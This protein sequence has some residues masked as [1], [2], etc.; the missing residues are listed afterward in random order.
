MVG[1]SGDDFGDGTDDGESFPK[2]YWR[3]NVMGKG[4]GDHA[5]ATETKPVLLMNL[6]P[7]VFRSIL[8]VHF[9]ETLLEVR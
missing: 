4:V 2:T 1:F 8:V 7:E 6:P 5:F 9:M 3:C